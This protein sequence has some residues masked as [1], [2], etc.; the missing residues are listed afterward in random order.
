M[1]RFATNI[2]VAERL[3]AMSN[4]WLAL[5]RRSKSKVKQLGSFDQ[6]LS[7]SVTVSFAAAARVSGGVVGVS[8]GS[9][10]WGT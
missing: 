7:P 6:E 3:A 4:E 9:W 10:Q 5:Q 2:D 8:S 1:M